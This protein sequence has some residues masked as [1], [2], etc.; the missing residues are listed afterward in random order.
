MTVVLS[1]R[2]D[3][4]LEAFRRV[5]WAGEE[6]RLSDDALARIAECRAAFLHL[7]ETEPDIVIYGVTS[8][9]GQQ[10]HLRFTPEER[11]AHAARPPLAAASAFGTPF[12][13]RVVRGVVLA[14]LANMVEGHAA[15]S[16]DL[17]TAVAATTGPSPTPAVPRVPMEGHGGAGE[18]L[19][20]SHLF[21]PLA[22][23]RT[24]A[25]KESL[26]L[27]NGSP[28]A[29]ALLADASLANRRRM[30]LAIEVMALSAEAFL[31]PHEAYD[32]ALDGLWGD[33]HEA[34]ALARFRVLL[35]GGAL[36]RRSYQAPVSFRI[37]PR[38]AA[39][40]LRAV[41]AAERA[42]ETSLAS[43]TDNPVYIAPDA[44]HPKGRALSTG[45]YHNAMAAPAMDS[46]AAAAADLCLLAER[47]ASKMLDG[48]VSGLPPQLLT[49]PDDRRYLGTTP[50]AAVGWGEQARRAAQTTFLP[51]PE[52]GGYGQN[53]V[54]TNAVPAWKAQE[55]AGR[56][57]DACLAILAVIASQALHVTERRA[58][59][60]L[61]SLLETIR[62]ASPPI[63]RMTA[64]GERLDVVTKIFTDRIHAP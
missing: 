35:A 31:A 45:G 38:M 11:K 16:A 49:G 29:A 46:L 4:S 59:A 14:R 25:E 13:E 43:V 36:E 55:E 52:S 61:S 56:C 39:R 1:R 28:A 8:G 9:Y 63:E 26:A 23:A 12:P 41:D 18:I 57:L 27:I 58:P 53:D 48:A 34:D 21:N 19:L 64:M 20:L 5:A 30:D 33:P 2:T 15:V 7:I 42:A 3:I 60:A 6:A 54:A 10:A 44:A 22:T 37:A 40:A 24:L 32:S 51:G 47:Q 17:A 62:A 50:M